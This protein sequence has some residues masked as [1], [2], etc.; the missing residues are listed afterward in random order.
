MYLGRAV[1][2]WLVRFQLRVVFSLQRSDEIRH[3]ALEQILLRHLN[4]EAQL[5]EDV[6]N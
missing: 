1:D 6:R 3:L 5:A 2:T 4:F